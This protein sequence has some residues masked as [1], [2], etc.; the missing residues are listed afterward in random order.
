MD[1]INKIICKDC[2]EGMKDI[3]ENYK[4]SIKNVKDEFRRD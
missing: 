3:P 4:H 2:I 1:L